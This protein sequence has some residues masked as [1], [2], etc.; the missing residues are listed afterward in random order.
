MH[1]LHN[2]HLIRKVLPR[3]LTK[4]ILQFPD[5]AALHNRLATRLR[6]SGP[7]K[8]AETKAKSQAT[9]ALKKAAK[10]KE[11]SGER[12]AAEGAQRGDGGEG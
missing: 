9:R 12:T 3:H 5:R 10:Q 11:G 4:P 6:E 2:S 1:A 8:R 7:A